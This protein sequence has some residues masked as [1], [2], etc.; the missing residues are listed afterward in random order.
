MD[1]ERF[2]NWLEPEIPKQFRGEFTMLAAQ[3]LRGQSR[4]LFVGFILSLPMVI[5]ARV[6]AA[7]HWVGIGLPLVILILSL[8][9]L[10]AV[11]EKPR[12]THRALTVMRRAWFACFAVAAM[13]GL[14]CLQSWLYAPVETRIYY[15]AMMSIGALTLGYT[16]TATRIVGVTAFLVTLVPISIALLATGELLA[17]ALAVGLLLA[18]VFQ[19]LLIERHQ[20]LLLEL[21]QE[22]NHSRELASIDPLTGIANRRA[23]VENAQKLAAQGDPIRMMILDIDQFKLVNDRYGHDTGDEVLMIVAKLLAGLVASPIQLARLGGEEFAIVGK[24]DDLHPALAHILLGQIREAEMPHG[25]QLTASIGIATG[26]LDYAAG[27][28]ELYRKA[29]SALYEAKIDGRNKAVE[30]SP[31]TEIYEERSSQRRRSGD[32]YILRQSDEG[33]LPM[34]L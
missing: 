22:R 23:L 29:D 33:F 31:R 19:A 5:A 16:L 2:R 3:H 25:D 20:R 15:V 10:W 13:G 34:S 26:T 12:D 9:G 1:R 4:L 11:H 32:E 14:W 30:F 21:V 8:A 17:S 28:S 6:E 7:P 24:S 27:W 18:V